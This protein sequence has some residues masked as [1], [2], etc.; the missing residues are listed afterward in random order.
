MSSTSAGSSGTANDSSRTPR[1]FG[2]RLDRILKDEWVFEE[3]P[4]LRI[5]SDDLWSSV[6]ARQ[7]TTRQAIV[8]DRGVRSERARRPHY[9]FSGL[10]TCGA[11]G[12]GYTLV[13]AR[14]YGCANTRN[15]G[16]CD[17][18]L[19]IRRDVL[20]ETVLSGLKDNLLQPELIHEFV[21]TYQ[22]EYN[23]LR[24]EQANEHAAAQ[25]SWPGSNGKS[26]TSSRP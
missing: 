18:R 5:V 19:T 21:T 7:S 9:L 26:A 16:T 1:W 12:G 2:A 24:R 10:L 23:R 22:Q 4:A 15:R 20:E 13:G 17:N 11:C 25:R 3:V 6:K 8:G 14:H